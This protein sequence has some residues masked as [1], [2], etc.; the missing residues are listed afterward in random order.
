MPIDI[1]RR[2]YSEDIIVGG[3]GAGRRR[4][5]TPDYVVPNQTD[6]YSQ[7]AVRGFYQNLGQESLVAVQYESRNKMMVPVY[8]V[9]A[10]ALVLLKRTLDVVPYGHLRWLLE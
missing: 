10:L 9:R 4:N 3:Y 6:S 8:G 2:P 5:R 7:D 1:V